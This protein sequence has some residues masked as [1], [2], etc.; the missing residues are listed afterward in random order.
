MCSPFW[1]PVCIGKG[2]PMDTNAYK[3]L[4]NA[5]I[6]GHK[7]NCSTNAHVY[8]DIGIPEAAWREGVQ[9]QFVKERGARWIQMHTNARQMLVYMN[10][11]G[12]AQQMLMYMEM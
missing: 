7:G 3:C 10:I 2:C 4:T 12:I 8:G 1:S 5:C 9:P 6:Y 11:K